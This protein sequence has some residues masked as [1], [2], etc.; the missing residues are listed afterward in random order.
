MKP[1]P[2][3]PLGWRGGCALIDTAGLAAVVLDCA[4]DSSLARFEIVVFST[5]TRASASDRAYARA[6]ELAGAYSSA[7]AYAYARA[8][9]S[10]RAYARASAA[11]NDELE[12]R[13]VLYS[14]AY[15]ESNA[16]ET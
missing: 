15:P 13:C 9:A 6:Y 10:A 8:Y 5:R 2:W 1:E 4:D 12:L 11:A 7:S 14:L 16:D 3:W